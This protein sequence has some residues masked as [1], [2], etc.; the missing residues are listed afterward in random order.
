MWAK[1]SD[2]STQSPEAAGSL[3]DD[4]AF[5]Q[6]GE[7]AR[8]VVHWIEAHNSRDLEEMLACTAEDLDFHPLRLTWRDARADAYLGHAGLRLWFVDLEDCGVQHLLLPAEVQENGTDEVLLLGSVDVPGHSSV[9]P[10]CGLYE[11]S[12]GLISRARHYISD[13]Q[14]MEALGLIQPIE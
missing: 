14:T 4:F 10:F 12:D 6:A 1:V 13:R 2:N 9:A 11:V 8:L 5:T 3:D 7:N